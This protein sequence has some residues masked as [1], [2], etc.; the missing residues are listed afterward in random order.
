VRLGEAL[1]SRA[2]AARARLAA[3]PDL[4][5]ALT[6]MLEEARR[7]WPSVAL[8]DEAFAQH[9]G[10]RLAADAQA[11]L[12]Q[13]QASDL[14]FAAACAAGDPAAVAELEARYMPR[15]AAYFARN[16]SL[17][18]HAEEL[19]QLVR[20][21]L[22]VSDGAARPRIAEY[23]G[24]APFGAWFRVL[25]SRLA[26]DYADA[27]K[28][29]SSRER[30]AP[31]SPDP[32]PELELL[33]THHRADLEAAFA[34]TLAALPPD[35]A[36]LLRLY[37]FEGVSA[38]A[39]GKLHAASARTVQRRIADARAEILRQVHERLGARLQLPASQVGSLVRAMHSQVDVSI[40][41]FFDGPRARG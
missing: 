28:I 33:R 24:R 15:A 41:R 11:D 39:I 23:S 9:L 8:G 10:E 30:Q 38:E 7:A 1:L 17:A 14:Y 21:R 16:G 34:A 31:T 27:R 2:G 20:V 22:L 32:D 40:H 19:M 4:E 13:V 25:V 29:D 26:I 36:T 18:P 5:G 6:A 35:T 12:A 37:Y 3:L